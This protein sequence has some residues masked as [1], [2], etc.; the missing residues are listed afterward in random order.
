VRPAAEPTLTPDAHPRRPWSRSDRRVPR[1][2]VRPLQEF[3]HWEA[4]GGALLLVATAAALVWANLDPGSYERIWTSEASLRIL[5]L[6]LTEDLRGAV[7]HGLMTLFFLVIGLEVK[8]ELVVGELAD[9]RAAL[10]PVAAALGAMA[11]PALIFLALAGDGAAARGWGIPM[12]TDT[13]FA[14]GALALLARR[15]LPAALTALL[16]GIAVV[17]DIVA[18]TVVAVAYSGHLS[19]PWLLGAGAGLLGLVALNRLGVRHLGPYL[20][21]GAVVWLATLESG[22]HATLAGVLIGLVTPV[23]P[24]Q[25]ASAVGAAAARTA[26][27]ARGPGVDPAAWRRLAWLSREA[28]APLT[29][30]EHALHPW[31]AALVLPLFALAN[32]GIA[33]GPEA[34]ADAFAQTPA[35]AVAMGLA[36][37]KPLGLALGALVAVRSGLA[38]LPAGVRPAHLVGI[39]ALAGIGFTV[40]IF[41]TELAYADD[42]LAASAKVGILLGSAVAAIAGSL[43]LL[44]ARGRRTRAAVRRA[45]PPRGG[46]AAPPGSQ[47][48]PRRPPCAPPAGS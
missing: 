29:R 3:L 27:V 1:T 8:R 9:R 17:D 44:R 46:I 7:N 26:A 31:T 14:L 40:S 42:A 41:V 35:L 28:I 2:V 36:V 15:R 45:A 34:I 48:P 5:G 11:V 4:A 38:R 32:A 39:G 6:S 13:A 18:L 30:L 16:L 25:P 43:V 47:P 22:V 24:F 23:R 19:V 21:V 20:A 33:I 10:L 37:G 12:A